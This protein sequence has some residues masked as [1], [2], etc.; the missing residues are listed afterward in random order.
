MTRFLDTTGLATL[1]IAVCDRCKTKVPWGK[2]RPD[3]NS[4]GLMVCE[5]CWDSLDPYR[6]PARQGEVITMKWTRPDTPIATH[7]SGLISEDGDTFITTEDGEGY[8]VP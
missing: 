2:L 3:A 5:E 7:P 6:L 1:A 4:P 8:L